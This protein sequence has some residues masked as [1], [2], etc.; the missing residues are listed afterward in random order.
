M[1]VYP[2]AFGP[3]P[4]HIDFVF[5]SISASIETH[6]FCTLKFKNIERINTKILYNLIQK[7]IDKYNEKTYVLDQVE[8]TWFGPTDIG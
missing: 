8:A 2:G 7:Y 5:K 4:V 6:Y 1:P 3:T